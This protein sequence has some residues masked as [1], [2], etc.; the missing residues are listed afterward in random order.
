MQH[1]LSR[2]GLETLGVYGLN[3]LE[4]IILA[5]LASESTLL[6]IGD[7]GSGKS[8]LLERL[9][10]ALDLQWRH[11]NT[12]LLSFDD[13]VGY[14]IP[15]ASGS[16]QFVKTPAAIWGAQA[17][18]F[19]EISRARPDIQNKVFPIIHERKVQG[20]TLEGLKFR[21]AAMN[22]PGADGDDGY[23]G[24]EPLDVALADRFAFH[25]TIPSWHALPETAQQNILRSDEHC[26]SWPTLHERLADIK[27]HA[28]ATHVAQG[29]RIADYTMRMAAGLNFAGN[30]ISARR[31]VMIAR[32]IAW[33]H[34]A[35]HGEAAADLTGP[36]LADSS[37]LALQNSLPW[38][39]SSSSIDAIKLLA[40]HR[41][42]SIIAYAE[43]DD[44]RAYVWKETDRVKRIDITLKLHALGVEERG[45]LIMDA[46]ATLN[47]EA[48]AA[49][50]ACGWWIVNHGKHE[51][52]P[53]AV[54]EELALLYREAAIPT[55]IHARVHPKSPRA[56]AYYRFEHLQK[57][58][59]ID[60]P[61]EV[62]LVHFLSSRLQSKSITTAEALDAAT[63]DW[64]RAVSIL[65]PKKE[66]ADVW[67]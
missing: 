1:D 60:N 14:P 31:A 63:A 37:W 28:A 62:A 8:M 11:Y 58:I 24:S 33:V 19:D 50:V 57:S 56:A 16:L 22:P 7:H 23:I 6:L 30:A 39:A 12:S 64:W 18:F 29:D 2:L 44:S 55:R 42:I 61:A 46:I 21:W 13:L 54:A 9:A 45:A 48:P 41:E 52:L 49:A 65:M 53:L 40:L 38:A 47:T 10:T 4:P 66:V 5:A 3:E 59:D 26:L 27:R 35:A 32:N 25:V 20:I 36:A 67:S 51:H 34:A 15:D 17:V 43:G